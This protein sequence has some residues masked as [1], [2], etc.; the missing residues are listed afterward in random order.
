MD[1]RALDESDVRSYRARGAGLA[2][3]LVAKIHKIAE[4]ADSPHRLNDKDAHDI[5]RLLVAVDTAP[6]AAT[7][8]ML[9]NDPLSGPA[10]R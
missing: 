2:A 6:I 4:R 5:Y 10:T 7:L 9:L 3:L 1:I 8:G